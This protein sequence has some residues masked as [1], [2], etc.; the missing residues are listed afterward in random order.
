M[1]ILLVYP[2]K[3]GEVS[4]FITADFVNDDAYNYPPMGLLAIAANV[5]PRHS[6]KV[7]D[8]CTQKLLIDDTV[9]FIVDEDPDILGI[10]MVSRRLYP[11]NVLAGKIKQLLPN[12]TIIAGGPHINDFPTETMA[13]GNYDYA[14]AGYAEDT[15]PQLVEVLDDLDNSS[16]RLKDIPGLYFT[17]NGKLHSNPSTE[18]PIILD[19]FPYPKREL[20]KLDDYYNATSRR[21]MTTIYTSRGCPY[22]CSF[23]DVQDKTYH[24]RST[25]SIVDEYEYIMSLGIQEIHI[26]DDTFNMGRK[27]VIDMCNEIISRGLKVNWSARV[28]AHPFDQE[29]LSIMKD[30]GCHQLQCGVESLLPEALKNMKKKVTLDHI[31]TFFSLTREAKIKTLGYFILGFPE[32]D[33]KYRQRFYDEMMELNPTYMFLSILYPLA[34]TPLYDDLLKNGTYKKDHWAE[35]FKEPVKDFDLPLFRP[36]ALQDELL[37]MENDLYKKFYLSPRFIVADLMRN[38]S[39][40]MLAKKSLIGLKLMLSKSSRSDHKVRV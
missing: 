8:C 20:I 33:A 31:R 24:Y 11:S 7:L 13:L 4:E 25:K 27:R 5:D 30:A 35:F 3:E 18:V 32:E 29:M 37:A 21:T 16:H 34:K 23:C 6:L 22:K 19:D 2:P 9:N 12:T 38:A 17:N 39:P 1:K 10:S 28:R 14:L 40:K 26:F 15:F 36:K